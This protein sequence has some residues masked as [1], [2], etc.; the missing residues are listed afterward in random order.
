MDNPIPR[1]PPVTTAT[2]PSMLMKSVIALVLPPPDL[3]LP[4]GDYTLM[5]RHRLPAAATTLER[6]QPTFKV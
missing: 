1:R 2:R 6:F 4:M 3:D 5:R